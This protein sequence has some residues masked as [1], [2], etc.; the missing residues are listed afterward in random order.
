MH[1]Q[2]DGWPKSRLLLAVSLGT[3]IPYVAFGFMDNFIMI[4]AGDAIDGALSVKLGLSTLAAA[5]LGN[6]LSDIVGVAAAGTIERQAKTL[7]YAEPE[8]SEER[9][10][11]SDV[12]SARFGGAV[13]GVS[14]G[15]IAGMAP[16][17]MKALFGGVP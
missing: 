1:R 10:E 9:S 4:V 12:A 2:A 5:G 7:G 3:M 6:M 15:C 17:G 14:L 16:L 13:A 8:M 11:A